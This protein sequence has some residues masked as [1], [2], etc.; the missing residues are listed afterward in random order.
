MLLTIE[1]MFFAH[2]RVFDT[3]QAGDKVTQN[4]WRCG[5][6]AADGTEDITIILQ[7]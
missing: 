7:D 1:H 2:E 5:T 3:L 4:I 6:E